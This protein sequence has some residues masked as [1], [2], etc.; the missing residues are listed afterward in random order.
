MES[1]QERGY[2]VFLALI[3]CRTELSG[4]CMAG[5]SAGPVSSSPAAAAAG[6]GVRTA[7][8]AAAAAA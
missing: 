5:R 4:D 7:W 6:A 1:L 8:T 3:F 2:L